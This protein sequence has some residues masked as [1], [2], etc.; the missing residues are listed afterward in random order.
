LYSFIYVSHSNSITNHPELLSVTDL[1]V[2]ASQLIACSFTQSAISA[3]RLSQIF[4]LSI[5]QQ[6]SSRQTMSALI[7]AFP[8]LAT[9]ASRQ[10]FSFSYVLLVVLQAPHLL[11]H[12]GAHIGEEIRG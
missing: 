9:T 7:V 6:T 2:L 3:S 11:R 5:S 10:C 4:E 8:R 12:L 1:N